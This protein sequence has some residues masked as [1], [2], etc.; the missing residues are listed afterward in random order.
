MH[1]QISIMAVYVFP[2]YYEQA[3]LL[4]HCPIVSLPLPSK[5]PGLSILADTVNA[6]PN[7]KAIIGNKNPISKIF[8]N[9]TLSN[10]VKIY[11]VL[12]TFFLIQNCRLRNTAKL[13]LAA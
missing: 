11:I 9:S 4:H 3:T 1:F 8:E 5:A 7:I 13:F 10:S 2:E 12:N 6:K